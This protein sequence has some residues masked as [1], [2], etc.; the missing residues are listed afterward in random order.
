MRALDASKDIK[1]RAVVDLPE[2]DSPTMAVTLPALSSRFISI[3]AGYQ[4]PS[5]QKSTLKS[6]IF[7][8]CSDM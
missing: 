7:N 6:L 2:P 5:T 4:T 3:T 1:P 8:T